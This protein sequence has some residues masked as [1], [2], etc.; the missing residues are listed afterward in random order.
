MELSENFA[1]MKGGKVIIGGIIVLS[2]LAFAM[3]TLAYP[4]SAVGIVLAIVYVYLTARQPI[5]GV[6]LAVAST[7][8]I[9]KPSLLPM[10]TLGG[11]DVMSPEVLII[12]ALITAILRYG[13][14]NSVRRILSSAMTLPLLI[15]FAL[16][17]VSIFHSITLYKDLELT[18]IISRSRTLFYYVL[19]F[20]VLLTIRDERDLRF[21]I[22]GL[23]V[24]TA[25]V[26]IYFI[27]TAM[28][29]WT[30]LHYYLRTGIVA[31]LKNVGAGASSSFRLREGRMQ[32]V[33][34][35]ALVVTMF[36]IVIGLFIHGHS[37]R[38]VLSYG[39]LSALFT[40][41]ILLT[42]TRTTWATTLF[43]FPVLWLLIRRKTFRLT[44]LAL[45]MGGGFLLVFLALAL[46]PKYADIIGFS[47]D[48]L[49]SF[50]VENVDTSTA[51]WRIVEMKAALEVVLD[52]PL[53]GMGV[54]GEF[55]RKAVEY[56]GQEFLLIHRY[57]VH[58]S[59]LT[60]SM[61]V[62]IPALVV[63]LYIYFSAI[64]GAFKVFRKSGNLLVKG[65]AIGVFIGLLRTFLNAFSQPYVVETAMIACLSIS[66]A[67]VEAM[68]GMPE[69]GAAEPRPAGSDL[70]VAPGSQP[71]R[72]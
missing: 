68:K 57:V 5:L 2:C 70:T 34:G 52:D 58:N 48:R 23:L 63:F 25:I 71:V 1:G 72:Y 7:S 22:N 66:F 26:S 8:S 30:P 16:V 47:I 21:L 13:V 41:P 27:Y 15:F 54:A 46:Y 64:V 11:A 36:F 49:K 24:I 42:F 31:G 29:G 12:L 45:I 65:I 56:E 3:V 35:T 17:V 50:F 67:L 40:I 18:E 33:P 62:G 69:R 37:S 6:L 61:K 55:V 38:R 43:M 10:V 14:N 39:F 20:P 32:D 4:E 44:K 53:F 9:F 28:F 60:L 59:F 51:L 19:F